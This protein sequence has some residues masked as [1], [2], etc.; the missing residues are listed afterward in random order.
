MCHFPTTCVWYIFKTFHF[1][2]TQN[3]HSPAFTN[4]SFILCS[5]TF[6]NFRNKNK[7]KNDPCNNLLECLHWHYTPYVTLII[8]SWVQLLSRQQAV[9]SGPSVMRIS[10]VFLSSTKHLLSSE[11][12]ISK[13]TL[14]SRYHLSVWSFQCIFV[15]AGQASGR[16]TQTYI[17]KQLHT[18]E[19][20]LSSCTL[21]Y[22]SE[23][24]PKLETPIRPILLTSRR[25]S[26]HQFKSC[27]I[28]RIHFTKYVQQDYCLVLQTHRVNGLLSCATDTQGERNCTART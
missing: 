14:D 6:H 12:K 23:D 22:L 10:S 28:F 11:Q 26:T 3:V 4:T 27:T 18:S 19:A 8:S 25:H 24:G 5:F 20:T 16:H 15:Y 1:K 13:Y 2:H 21:M 7:N 17:M 9:I